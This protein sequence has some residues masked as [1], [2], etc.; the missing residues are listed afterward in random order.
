MLVVYVWSIALHCSLSFLSYIHM[1]KKL[2]KHISHHINLARHHFRDVGIGV[3]RSGHWR[4]L[5]LQFLSEHPT[6][7]ACG[8]IER[9]QVHHLRPFHLNPELELDSANLA[10]ACMGPK[11]CHLKIFHGGSFKK[12]N[13]NALADAAE[14]LAHP[15]RFEEIV[16]RAAKNAQKN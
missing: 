11:E 7:Y 15:E 3:K 5:E 1:L 12:F 13:P 9:L 8:G 2:V 14:A 4:T 10:T 16:A 6:C